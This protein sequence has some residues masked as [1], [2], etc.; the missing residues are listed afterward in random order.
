MEN[1]YPRIDPLNYPYKIALRITPK[2]RKQF[3]SAR[4]TGTVLFDDD[5]IEITTMGYTCE[6]EF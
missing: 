2:I 1:D 5:R 6:Y 3:A 4:Y